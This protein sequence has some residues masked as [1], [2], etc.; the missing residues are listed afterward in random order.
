MKK[1]STSL[2]MA[3]SMCT[4]FPL[5]MSNASAAPITWNAPVAI[6]NGSD[7]VDLG[8]PVEAAYAQ[9]SS[10]GSGPQTVNGVT[11]QDGFGAAYVGAGGVT[12]GP[13]SRGG[14]FTNTG[15]A[16]YDTVLNGFAYD[17]TNPGVLTLTGLTPGKSYEIQLWGLDSSGFASRT[18]SYSVD[19][20]PTDVSA[21]FNM[22]PQVSVTGT[23]V[24]DNTGT[25]IIDVNGVGQ[26]QHNFNAFSLTV[27]TP[28]PT[29]LAALAGLGCMGLI[30][31]AVRRRR[32]S[33]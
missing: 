14:N 6:G 17:G 20:S 22:F 1:I 32:R 15:N 16:A 2:A 31:F 5:A 4:V 13:A 12:N 11:F 25:E 30:G 7:V 28:E 3:I 26:G 29:T 10:L 8:K 33:A 24:A 18:E 9:D 21:T 23:F 27:Q 19:G